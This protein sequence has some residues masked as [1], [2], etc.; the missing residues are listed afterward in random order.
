MFSVANAR[1]A[2]GEGSRLAAQL[3]NQASSDQQIVQAIQRIVGQTSLYDVNE[4]DIYKLNQDGNGNLTQD[5]TRTNRYRSDG[6][7]ML[8]PEPWLAA[9]RDVRSGNSDF[10]GVTIN[11]TYNWK[12]GLFSALGPVTTTAT[13]YIRLEPQSFP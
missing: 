2:A 12:A 1:F 9:S 5:P 8:T 3:G 13:V 6:S 7:A 10:L 4:I 11:Y